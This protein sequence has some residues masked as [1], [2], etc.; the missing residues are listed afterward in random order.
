MSDAD[1]TYVTLAS[2]DPEA[3]GT[4]QEWSN[5]LPYPLYIGSVEDGRMQVACI[6]VTVTV[7]SGGEET[8]FVNSDVCM[9][10]QVVG[11]QNTDSLRRF[12]VPDTGSTTTTTIEFQ[13]PMW[14]DAVRSGGAITYISTSIT[15]A[16][17]TK[18]PA[19]EIIG[20]TFVTLAFRVVA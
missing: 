10:N 11:S 3:R 16:K 17:P 4:A 6:S 20:D 19:S 12:T 9:G 8:F 18:P 7:T 14:L 1:W 15:H 2:N 13:N 5:A